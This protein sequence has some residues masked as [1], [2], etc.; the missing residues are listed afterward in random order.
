MVLGDEMA[1][2]TSEEE[3]FN[4]W[5][6]YSDV[7]Y[8]IVLVLVF[9]L[10]GQ[11]VVTLKTMEIDKIIKEQTLLSDKLQQKFPQQYGT[12]IMDYKEPQLQKITFSNKI[13][14][15]SGS[16]ELKKSG[17][18]ILQSIALILIALKGK[19]YNCSFDEIQIRGHTDNVPI[20]TSNYPDNWALSSARAT[21][22]VSYFDKDCN[23]RPIE[24]LLISAQ[25]YSEFDN[26]ASNSSVD[27]RALNRRIEIVIKYPISF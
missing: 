5:P 24:G 12:I 25:G 8:A 16:A 6:T 27:G 11:F 1:R 20:Y 18:N 3:E 13:L 21:S 19:K 17:K 26:I 7:S 23:L 10:L 4:I 9:I 22:V 15:D 2:N 14:F